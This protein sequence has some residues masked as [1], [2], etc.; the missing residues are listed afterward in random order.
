M[1]FAFHFRK[2]LKIRYS[3]PC[4]VEYTYLI[5][6][7][8]INMLSIMTRWTHLFVFGSLR[9]EPEGNLLRS[10]SQCEWKKKAS[11]CTYIYIYIYMQINTQAATHRHSSPLFVLKMYWFL[12]ILNIQI[13]FDMNGCT[14]NSYIFKRRWRWRAAAKQ[15]IMPKKN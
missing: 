10:R 11:T 13:Y 1:A 12:M 5:P 6:P 14:F 4:H 9:H 15:K 3:T 8:R 2:H 7:L